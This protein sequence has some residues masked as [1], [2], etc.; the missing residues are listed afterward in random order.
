MLRAMIVERC[1]EHS[2]AALRTE[3]SIVKPPQ[4]RLKLSALLG[5][6]PSDL[7]HR[8]KNKAATPTPEQHLNPKPL[9]LLQQACVVSTGH[10]ESLVLPGGAL[11]SSACGNDKFKNFSHKSQTMNGP[12]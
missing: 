6:S 8:A 12:R 4:Q 3:L 9:T 1:G 7:C 10:T 11:I 5:L 2:I